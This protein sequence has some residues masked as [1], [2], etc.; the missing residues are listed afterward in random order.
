MSRTGSFGKKFLSHSLSLIAAML[1][2]ACCIC[3]LCKRLFLSTVRRRRLLLAILIVHVI[4]TYFFRQAFWNALERFDVGTRPL[5]ATLERPRRQLIFLQVLF[6]H[7]HHSPFSVYPLDPT[8]DSYWIEGL[9]QLTKLGRIQHYAMGKHFRKMYEDFLSHDVQEVECLSSIAFRSLFAGYAFLAGFYPSAA[10]RSIGEGLDW[11]PVPCHFLPL[12]KDKYL[13]SLPNCPAAEMDKSVLFRTKSAAQF[14][15]SYK[16]WSA[17]SGLSVQ[18][19]GDAGSLYKTLLAEKTENLS[20]PRWAEDTWE[21]LESNGNVCYHFHFK[22][23]LLHRLRA[24]PVVEKIMKQMRRKAENPN[25]KLKVYVYSGHGSNVAAVLQA[26]LVFNDRIPT[27]GSTI[28]FELY[29]EE[30]GA[31]TV[32]LLLSNSTYPE[33]HIEEPHVLYMPGCPEYCPL[34]D[35]ERSTSDLYPLDWERECLEVDEQRLWG[36]LSE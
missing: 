33:R 31:H 22:T 3:D 32:R 35:M 25:D 23:R 1:D 36:L 34:E 21:H 20:I 15:E 14:M 27:Y 7:G 26:L 18:N 8:P 9:G 17:K 2:R 28:L 10:G 29:K 19:Y 16:F 24:G 30:D 4:A 6:R 12:N 13:Q 5:Q 11:Q